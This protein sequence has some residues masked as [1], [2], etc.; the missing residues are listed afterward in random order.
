MPKTKV[1]RSFSDERITNF[2]DESFTDIPIEKLTL[3]DFKSIFNDTDNYY[4]Y[5]FEY[6]DDALG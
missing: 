5:H 4:S 3:K 1:I 6:F 2:S